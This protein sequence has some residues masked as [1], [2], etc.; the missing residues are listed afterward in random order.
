MPL[1]EYQ[2]GNGT[3]WRIW[4][5]HP[6]QRAGARPTE[7]GP[8]RRTAPREEERSR[9]IATPGLEQGWLC[10]ESPVEKRRLTPI[11]EQWESCPEGELEALLGRAELVRQRGAEGRAATGPDDVE[12]PLPGA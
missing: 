11:P 7:E 2:D 6:T 9:M 1:R 12:V 4:N 5:V 3:N 10:F 8:E